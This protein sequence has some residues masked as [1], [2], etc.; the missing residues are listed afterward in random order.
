M[1]PELFHTRNLKLIQLTSM[2][3]G[4]QRTSP[5]GVPPGMEYLALNKSFKWFLIQS[6]CLKNTG[7]VNKRHYLR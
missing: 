2:L 4:C 7:V 1:T 5:L 3:K 6:L